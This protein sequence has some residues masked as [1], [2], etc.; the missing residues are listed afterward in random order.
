MGMGAKE[1]LDVLRPHLDPQ[2][3]RYTLHSTLNTL[4]STLYTLHS[5]L[6]TLHSTLYTLHLQ[7]T[8]DLYSTFKLLSF[9][10]TLYTQHLSLETIVAFNNAKFSS[11]ILHFTLST[12]SLY[13]SALFT[14]NSASYILQHEWGKAGRRL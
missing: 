14:L 10:S 2:G 6:Y 7:S 12:L 8:I 3:A 4:H 1:D 5:T 11:F 13:T 9:P